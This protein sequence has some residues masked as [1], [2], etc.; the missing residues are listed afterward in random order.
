MLQIN[1]CPWQSSRLLVL[2]I[3]ALFGAETAD[4]QEAS[5]PKRRDFFGQVSLGAYDA[6]D[7]S[8]S[9]GFV[10]GNRYGTVLRPHVHIGVDVDWYHSSEDT[11]VLNGT[12]RVLRDAD[13]DFFPMMGYIQF[14]SGPGSRYIPYIGAGAGYQLA[15]IAARDFDTEIYDSWGWGAW[16]GMGYEFRPYGVSTGVAWSLEVSFHESKVSR[17]ADDPGTGGRT[18]EFVDAGGVGYRFG[19]RFRVPAK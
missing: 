7:E 17:N 9:T 5:A 6:R 13:F 14:E 19:I 15:F 18:R 11:T 3:L 1:R 12:N 4:A 2:A 16:A 8:F 10:L